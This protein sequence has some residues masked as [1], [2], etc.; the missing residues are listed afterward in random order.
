M[1]TGLPVVWCQ[2]DCDTVQVIGNNNNTAYTEATDSMVYLNMNNPAQCNGTISSYQYCQY[3]TTVT[4]G[5]R[6]NAIL[7]VFRMVDDIYQPVTGSDVVLEERNALPFT[8]SSSPLNTGSVQIQPGDVLGACVARDNGG[9]SNRRQLN[10]AGDNNTNGLS[11]SGA[12]VTLCDTTNIPGLA[13]PVTSLV[14]IPGRILHLSAEF[15]E[16]V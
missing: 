6:Y 16:S 11:V 14:D 7:A 1:L 9:G 10:L 13:T 4:G 8:C 3:P 5:V 15:S 2:S 12:S